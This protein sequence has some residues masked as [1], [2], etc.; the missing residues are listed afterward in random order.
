MEHLD[1]EFQ[2]EVVDEDVAHG[3]EEIPDNLRP[4]TQSR[5]READM[6]CHPETR[7]ESDRKL[8]YKGGD[9]RCESYETEVEHLRMENKMVENIVQNPLQH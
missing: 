8:E 2:A 5:P 6:S 4:A 1:E 9:M 7:Q 3:N